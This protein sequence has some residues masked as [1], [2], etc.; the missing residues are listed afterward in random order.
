V[1]IPQP[2]LTSI[3][4]R[5]AIN[6]LILCA[7]TIAAGA[8]TEVGQICD[9][10][11]DAIDNIRNSV[12][13]YRE[14]EDHQPPDPVVLWDPIAGPITDSQLRQICEDAAKQQP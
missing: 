13:F 2:P 11:Q 6:E 3:E 8:Y 10:L 4:D 7:C 5:I 12:A 14:H 9:R 1:S